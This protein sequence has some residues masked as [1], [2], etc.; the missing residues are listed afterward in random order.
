M[1]KISWTAF[2][3]DRSSKIPVFEQICMSI[4]QQII[5]GDLTEGMKLPPTRGFATDL[6]VSRSTIV[7]AYEQLVAEGY[8]N[9][10]QGA[11]FTV[12]KIGD[13]E[14]NT[15]K[16]SGQ[17]DQ[18]EELPTLKPLRP[19][20]PDMTLFPHRQWGKT[21]ARV[22]RSKPE[23]M[24]VGN[25][26]MGNFDLRKQVAKHVSEWR[27]IETSAHQIV[28]T[29]GASDGVELCIHTLAQ[30]QDGIA[31]EDPGYLPLR[32]FVERLGYPSEFMDMDEEGAIVPHGKKSPKIVIITPSHQ[33]PLGGAMSPSRRMEF[34]QWAEQNNNWVVED[35]Y[36]SEFRYAGRPIPAMAGFDHNNRTIYVG[37][38]SKM[39]SSNLRLGYVVFPTS[40]ME[41]AKAALET[42]GANA[43]Y[44]PQQILAEFMRD[45]EFYRH[46]RRVRRIY[47]ERRKCITD[48]LLKDFSSYGHFKNHQAG[49]QLV[50]YLNDNFTD[51]DIV[52]KAGKEGLG[53]EAMSSFCSEKTAVNGLLLGFSAFS[54]D[55]ITASMGKLK[56]ILDN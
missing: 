46:L 55:E 20:V 52:K 36:D 23:K 40:L 6:G 37:T 31:L 5:D 18:E 42:H 14:L 34:I 44:M 9:S 28:I 11:G 19:S 25:A 26:A 3:I 41:K 10:T 30:K 43:S 1:K 12:S 45:G 8:L 35:D 49:M 7:T 51:K 39:F 32:N 56:S 15:Q 53:V 48:I 27:G 4:R 47:G 33:Y 2:R 50:F 13:V 22:C 38:F 16:R 54:V 17:N 21:V 24:L 29:A